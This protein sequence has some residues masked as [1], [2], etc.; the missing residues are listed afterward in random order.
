MKM[1]IF[2][3]ILV[4]KTKVI[5]FAVISMTKIDDFVCGRTDIGSGLLRPETQPDINQVW[6]PKT[7][8]D[9]KNRVCNWV[10]FLGLGLGLRL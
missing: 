8:P 5:L 4:T 3:I 10:S 1:I 2:A 6:L 7:R 9:P